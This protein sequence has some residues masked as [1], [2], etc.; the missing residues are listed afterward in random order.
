MK[1]NKKSDIPSYLKN[2]VKKAE[3]DKARPVRS[4]G[5]RQDKPALRF[6]ADE[7]CY[8]RDFLVKKL[9]GKS[10]NKIK[11]IL[12]H[13]QV[14]VNGVITSKY[15]YS[16]KAGQT[17]TVKSHGA[18]NTAGSELLNIIY[19]DDQIVAINKPAGL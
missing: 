16:V 4:G 10:F 12:Y 5:R 7:D 11:S 17:V 3:T 9:Q 1:N 19:E 6:V 18:K 2:S 8:L 14:M 15:D 13:N